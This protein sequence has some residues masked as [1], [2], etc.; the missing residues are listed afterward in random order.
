MPEMLEPTTV[1]EMAEQIDYT[2]LLGNILTS[3][4]NTEYAFQLISGFLLFF[5]VVVLCYFCYKFFRIFF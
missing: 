1:I 4:Q 3:C 2:E 5:V